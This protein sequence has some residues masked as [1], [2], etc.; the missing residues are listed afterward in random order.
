[1]GRGQGLFGVIET[2]TLE[3][4]HNSH[5]SFKNTV[6]HKRYRMIVPNTH[7]MHHSNILIKSIIHDGRNGLK[8]Y[9]A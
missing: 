4:L 9:V 5:Y 8:I 2:Y 1:M 6:S 3:N 7:Q